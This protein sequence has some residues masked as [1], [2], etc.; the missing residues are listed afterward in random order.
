MQPRQGADS[1]SIDARRL[2]AGRRRR[3]RKTVSLPPV[4]TITAGWLIPRSRGS[5]PCSIVSDLSD[6]GDDA[7]SSSSLIIQRLVLD[8]QLLGENRYGNLEIIAL[9]AAE[10][11]AVADPRYSR[12]LS[13][14]T[15]RRQFLRQAGAP[16]PHE[17]EKPVTDMRFTRDEE[18][19]T[20]AAPQQKRRR[21]ETSSNFT[22]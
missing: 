17:E 1:A 5:P 12:N 18:E 3:P 13:E 21:S 9:P 7:I 4:A 6:L 16:E 8:M 19:P 11:L 10:C 20:A 15:S 14:Q 2:K 22:S